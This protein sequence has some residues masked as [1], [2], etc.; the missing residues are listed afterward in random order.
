MLKSNLCICERTRLFPCTMVGLCKVKPCAWLMMKLVGLAEHWGSM[1]R[2]QSSSK[3]NRQACNACRALEGRSRLWCS[4]AC[5]LPWTSP[6]NQLTQHVWTEQC[7]WCDWI[8]ANKE[9]SISRALRPKSIRS[10][11]CPQ[12]L[13]ICIT[14]CRLSWRL[15]I[16]SLLPKVAQRDALWQLPPLAH[17]LL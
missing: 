6:I 13:T 7:R 14:I 15:D 1:S 8:A 9:Y 16:D 11:Y 10:P 12:E 5:T 2:L 17:I 3:N 4:D